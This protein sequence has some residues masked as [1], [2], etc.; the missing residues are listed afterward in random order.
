M[1]LKKKTKNFINNFPKKNKNS[2]SFPRKQRR[3][4]QERKKR[5]MHALEICTNII[6]CIICP[7]TLK[8][9]LTAVRT[10]HIHF[11]DKP[12]EPLLRLVQANFTWVI[13]ATQLSTKILTLQIF[14]VHHAVNTQ[15]VNKSNGQHRSHST[16][17]FIEIFCYP[18]LGKRCHQ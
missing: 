18:L 1:Q 8:R 9:S 11:K 7:L 5:Y 10:Y 12:T 4:K 6:S 14:S 13:N 17:F 16:P 15:Q 3:K 2:L